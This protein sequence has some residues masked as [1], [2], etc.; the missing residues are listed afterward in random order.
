MTRARAGQAV[1]SP[2]MTGEP[3]R[4][5]EPSP[6]GI[7][8]QAELQELPLM[9]GGGP[10]RRLHLFS[11]EL[12][13]PQATL[14][15]SAS[16]LVS[17]ILGALRQ[18]LFNAEFGAGQD[19]SA[20]YAAFRLPDTLFSLIAGGALSSAM[21]PV[22]VSARLRGG[23]AAARRLVNLVLT[24]VLSVFIVLVLLGEVFAPYFVRYILAPG[25]DAETSTLATSLTRLMLLQPLFL[26]AGS[27]AVAVLNARNQFVLTALSV[28]SHNITLIAGIIVAHQFDGVGIWGPAAGVVLGGVLQ[29]AIVVPGLRNGGGSIRFSWSPHDPELRDVARLLIPNGLVVASGYAGHIID[30]AFASTAREGAALAAIQNAW[31]LAG[32]PITLVGQAVGQAVFPR[33]AAQ[34][35]RADWTAIR[36]N[37]SF[38]TIAVTLL[39]LPA[40]A[41]IFIAGRET[42]RLLFERGEFT[43]ANG[44]LTFELLR[45]YALALPA[46]VATDIVTRGLI[47]MRDTRTPLFVNIGQQVLRAAIIA[48][49]ID[50]H[51]ALA[52]P[53]ALVVT[54]TIETFVLAL[55]FARRLAIRIRKTNLSAR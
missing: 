39:V 45:V 30:T 37:V 26:A 43:E 19:A 5:T 9:P 36:R 44:A 28:M 38:T 42:I 27:V 8:P 32:L 34:A 2:Q 25:F 41:G 51:G 6:I 52:I 48:I 15:L 14:M 55:I 47:A 17:A 50:D 23:E 21:I 22:L 20:Y 31:L 54:A 13:V 1:P 12:S 16:F 4:D 33:F 46:F 10:E 35:A 49:L 3:A 11:R 29:A 7:S 18:V 40:V 53:I 24:A